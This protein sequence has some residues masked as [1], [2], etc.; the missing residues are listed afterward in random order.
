MTRASSI[1]AN[2]GLGV[3][4]AILATVSNLAGCRTPASPFTFN[5]KP[6]LENAASAAP[7]DR[8]LVYADIQS[9]YF[10][11]QSYKGFQAGLMG[12]LAD[13]GIA[14][15]VLPT[16]PVNADDPAQIELIPGEQPP[17]TA[18][19]IGLSDRKIYKVYHPGTVT[20]SGTLFFELKIFDA[21]SH[22]VIW[23]AKSSFEFP[24]RDDDELHGMQFAS[25]L[26]T[27]LQDDGMLNRCRVHEA[28]PG[29]LQQRR[30]LRL[31]ASKT[32]D[33]LERW[34][35]FQSAPSCK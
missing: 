3:A 26:I 21:T 17:T 6:N 31:Q 29:C 24:S 22:K 10:N 33:K 12:R 20:I 23:L 2:R 25:N 34:K 30:E 19:S 11:D 7:I 27:R 18:M 35:L 9:E 5:S 1:T 13:C 15:R 16:G 32:V 8:L 28:Y 14:S 4:L